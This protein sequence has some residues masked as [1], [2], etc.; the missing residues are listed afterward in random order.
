MH[1]CVQHY[2]VTTHHVTPQNVFYVFINEVTGVVI[3]YKFLWCKG[4]HCYTIAF[5]Y[6]IDNVYTL[7]KI[8]QAINN[9]IATDKTKNKLVVDQIVRKCSLDLVEGSHSTWG[10][11]QP[12]PTCMFC[13]ADLPLAC[14]WLNI[15]SPWRVLYINIMSVW[16]VLYT[17]IM[18]AGRVLY[19]TIMSAW[20]MLYTNIMSAGRVLYTNIKSPWSMLYI[21]TMS[22]GRVLYTNIMFA[23]RVLYT[24]IKSPWSVLYINTMSAGRVLYTNIMSPWS[25]L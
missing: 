16:S 20:N 18:S 7:N 4:R 8:E 21:N 5:P 15:M 14:S 12:N 22:A 3:Y 2:D 13:Q 24:N 23:W 9:K 10:R 11:L 25:V 6:H 19:I 1:I 17:N